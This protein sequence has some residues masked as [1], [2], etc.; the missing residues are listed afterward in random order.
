MT[1]EG[2]PRWEARFRAPSVLMPDWS[3]TAPDRI[4]YEST[5]SGVYQVHCWDRGHRRQ[6]A[7][8]RSPRGRRRRCPD[9]RRRGCPVLAGRDRERGRA[10]VHPA[11]RGWRGPALPAGHAP[12]LEPRVRP[13][14]G[15][16]RRRD[17]RSRRVRGVRRGRRSTRQGVGPQHRG[18][19]P[20][21]LPG[22]GLQ[23]RS[24]VLGRNPVDAGTRRARRPDPPGP[25]RDRPSNGRRDRR[26]ARRGARPQVL[27]LV[28]DR[29]RPA[30]GDP[31]RTLRRGATRHLEPRD[32][33]A[34]RSRD[35]PARGDRGPRLVARRVGVAPDQPL[36][37]P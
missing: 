22:R 26:A 27:V 16:R 5:E 14:T 10:V 25:S 17:Q 12:G 18:G 7:G 32:G 11:V 3:P 8:D 13:G 20:G 35:R 37:R 9:A 21:G 23:S 29:G 24:A 33:R 2:N 30:A 4:V 6:A 36:R 1:D 19:E 31:A 34:D 28:A 15:G